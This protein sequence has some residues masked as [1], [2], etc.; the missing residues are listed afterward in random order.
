MSEAKTT[1]TDVAP[2]A[3]IAAVESPAKRADALVLDAL[4]R[5]VTGEEPKMWGRR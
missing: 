1:I 3:F 2:G 4:F 5:R